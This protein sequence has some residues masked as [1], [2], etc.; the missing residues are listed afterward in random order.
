MHM[1]AR[2]YSAIN[3]KR[4]EFTPDEKEHIR[5]RLDFLVQMGYI[6][7]GCRYIKN[8]VEIGVY[9]GRLDERDSILVIQKNYYDYSGLKE[10]KRRFMSFM[11]GVTRITD[12]ERVVYKNG[13]NDIFDKDR[14][15][16]FDIFADYLEK[17]LDSILSDQGRWFLRKFHK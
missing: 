2:E 3:S 12:I 9:S 8:D 16:R 13:Y 4:G 15:E 17:N 5:K 1:N 10:Q 6:E 11:F 14:M 7:D